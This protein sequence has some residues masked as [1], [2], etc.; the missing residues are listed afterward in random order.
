MNMHETSDFLGERLK[1]CIISEFAYPLLVNNEIPLE[2]SV[3]HVG[4]AELQMV[5]LARE[6]SRRSYDVT[7]VTMYGFDKQRNV[8]NGIK[9]V[10]PFELKRAG[11]TYLSPINFFRLLKIFNEINADIF[12][13]RAATPLTGIIALYSKLARK[14]FF[15]SASS[16][17]NVSTHL[18]INSF[19]CLKN[20]P[21]RFGVKYSNIVVC[22]TEKQKR[23]LKSTIGR[24]GIVIKNAYDAMSC[25]S[26][27]G[28][29]SLKNIV[30]WIG[31]VTKAKQPDLFLK[32]ATRLPHVR[33][34]MVASP[35]VGYHDYYDDIMRAA[36]RIE[37][38][39]FFGFLPHSQVEVVL[40]KAAI[41]VVLQTLKV[42]RIL[43]LKRG[44]L[45]RYSR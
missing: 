19:K 10:T 29:F 42:S 34:Q 27:Q 35:S 1:V 41:L 45:S 31:R 28:D 32:L 7:V 44:D 13:Q 16:D 5:L 40:S 33:F 26:K 9:I 2:N 17:A 15:F 24:E 43:F 8:I 30:L 36:N 3:N 39:D 11:Y 25:S 22:Q 38:L 20:I 37:N 6:L 21:Y 4:G 12:I 18:H 14:K 23:L